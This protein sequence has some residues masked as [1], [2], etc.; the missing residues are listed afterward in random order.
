MRV[1]HP[2]GALRSKTV[3]GMHAD[4]LRAALDD[5]NLDEANSAFRGKQ[6]VFGEPANQRLIGRRNAAPPD[7]ETRSVATRDI[8]PGID[9]ICIVDESL[10]SMIERV[11]S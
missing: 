5:M 8:R 7:D 11:P 1:S 3:C 6:N 9:V 2:L 4:A 10:R